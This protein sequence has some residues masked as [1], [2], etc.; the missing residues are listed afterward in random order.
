MDSGIR[1]RIA[2]GIGHWVLIFF[3]LNGRFYAGRCCGIL[4]TGIGSFHNTNNSAP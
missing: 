1:R 3:Y 4:S 2:A